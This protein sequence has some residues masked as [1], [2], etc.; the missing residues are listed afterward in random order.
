MGILPKGIAPNKIT[1]SI[2]WASTTA[3]FLGL[4]I[5]SAELIT[6]T[7]DYADKFYWKVAANA[8]HTNITVPYIDSHL[9]YVLPALATAAVASVVKTASNG[10]RD[11]FSRLELETSDLLE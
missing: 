2:S 4:L 8:M 1:P 9:G 11:Y 3:A 7:I 5:P 10:V 6:K